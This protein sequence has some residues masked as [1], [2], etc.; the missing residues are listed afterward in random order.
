MNITFIHPFLQ[1]R[2]GLLRT[3]IH[4]TILQIA[5][6]ILVPLLLDGA[7]SA[8]QPVQRAHPGVSFVF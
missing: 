5:V 1:L 4:G 7:V 8:K 2:E 6:R 3:R